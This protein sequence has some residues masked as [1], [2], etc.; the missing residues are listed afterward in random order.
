MDVRRMKNMYPARIISEIIAAFEQQEQELL[1]RGQPEGRREWTQ[2][3]K[4]TLCK[5]GKRLGCMTWATGV[6]KY[7]DGPEWLYDVVWGNSDLIS[8]PMVAECE[9]GDLGEIQ[10]DF[11][12][13]LLARATV[14]VMVCDSWTTNRDPA[15]IKKELRELVGAFYGA[16]GDIYL[17]IIMVYEDDK[18][19]EFSTIRVDDSNTPILSSCM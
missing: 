18:S 17:L 13:L 8:V 10:Y 11:S 3:V 1:Q 14:R 12:K 19:F 16:P 4:T 15:P 6:P 5:L 7:C 9:W 2:T